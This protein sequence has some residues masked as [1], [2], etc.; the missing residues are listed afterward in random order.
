MT[1]F[2]LVLVLCLAAGLVAACGDDDEESGSSEPQK[3]AATVTQDGKR[4]KLDAPGSINAG[5]VEID[6]RND[7]RGPAD[8]TL[9]KVDGDQTADDVRAIPWETP[10]PRAIASVSLFILAIFQG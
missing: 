3:V 5:V 1:K 6:F 4:P 2:R 10:I 8:L 7:A 9:V